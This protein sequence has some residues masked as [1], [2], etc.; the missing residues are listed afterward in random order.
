MYHFMSNES[1]FLIK[2]SVKVHANKRNNISELDIFINKSL[3]NSHLCCKKDK[4]HYLIMCF[5]I[6]VKKERNYKINI[7]LVDLKSYFLFSYNYQQH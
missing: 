3:L 1:C 4:L 6:Y 5:L 2:F 7:N